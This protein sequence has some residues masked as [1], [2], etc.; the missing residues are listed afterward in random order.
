MTS[1]SSLYQKQKTAAM[2]KQ[3]DPRTITTKVAGVT[4][5]NR[6]RVVERLVVGERLRLYREPANHYD[7]NA[8]CVQ[9]ITGEQV[10]YIPKELAARLAP[11][12]DAQGGT[13]AAI[14]ECLTGD[15]AKGLSR[16]VNIR[17]TLAS[18]LPTAFEELDI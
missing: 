12:M 17:F 5:D 6:P 4:F 13:V 7:P 18:E 9:T 14:V 8:I 1:A 10:G 3:G 15:P 16:R 2:A 11:V